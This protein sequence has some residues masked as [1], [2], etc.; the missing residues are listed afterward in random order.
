MAHQPRDDELL[1]F[2]AAPPVGQEIMQIYADHRTP[3]TWLLWP[4]GVTEMFAH[5]D[6]V[7]INRDHLVERLLVRTRHLPAR[8]QLELARM[9]VPQLLRIGV[10]EKARQR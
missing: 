2:C 4:G 1:I 10:L 6:A 5:G 8:Y 7:E 9:R 3:G